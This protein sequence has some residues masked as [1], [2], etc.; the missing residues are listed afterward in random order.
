MEQKKAEKILFTSGKGGVGK[1]TLSTT[2]AKI[3]NSQGEKVLMIDF[4][5]SLR[6]LDIMLSVSD[7]VLYDWY[8]VITERCDSEAALLK[9]R[10]P[11]LLA[12]PIGDVRVNEEDIKKLVSL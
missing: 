5:I 8:D 2:F 12:A 6:T 4:D 1:S 7:T 3:L 9:T 11:Y 10:G